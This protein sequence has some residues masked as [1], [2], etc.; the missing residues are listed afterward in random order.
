MNV[1]EYSLR[2]NSGGLG[3]YRGGLGVVRKIQTKVPVIVSLL[4][5]RQKTTPWGLQEGADGKRGYY[6][7][8]TKET[9]EIPL[10]SKA[11][12]LL[13]AYDSS[14]KRTKEQKID[15]EQDE[16]MTY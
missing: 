4:G 3:E 1:I 10:N 15:D 7:R 9:K 11:S 14:K 8:T 13:D 5:E 2:E 6:Y 12:V 16:K